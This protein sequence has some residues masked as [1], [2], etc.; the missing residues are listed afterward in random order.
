MGVDS[1]EYVVFRVAVFFQTTDEVI[2]DL[3]EGVTVDIAGFFDA[4]IYL[5]ELFLLFEAAQIELVVEDG[6]VFAD[7]MG[8]GGVGHKS[9]K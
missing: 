4:G 2:D 5:E 8:I 3:R 9:G 6:A 7:D 1:R